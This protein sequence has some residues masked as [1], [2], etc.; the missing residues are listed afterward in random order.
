MTSP[1]KRPL[2][3]GPEGWRCVDVGLAGTARWSRAMCLWGLPND[4]I[5]IEKLQLIEKLHDTYTRSYGMTV[6]RRYTRSQING[7]ASP[8]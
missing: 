8:T 4:I 5:L 7:T 1:R 6:P 2:G 3:N